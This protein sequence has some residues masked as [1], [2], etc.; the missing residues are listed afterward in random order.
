MIYEEMYKYEPYEKKLS[1]KWG[2]QRREGFL[3]SEL[4]IGSAS[5]EVRW[6]RG[7]QPSE[8]QNNLASRIVMKII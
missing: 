4:G 3:P 5:V 1:I 8:F 6:F 2:S 7:H